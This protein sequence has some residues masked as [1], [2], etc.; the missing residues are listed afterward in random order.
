MVAAALLAV[1][2]AA[3]GILG[4]AATVSKVRRDWREGSRLKYERNNTVRLPICSDE[5]ISR[6]S[7]WPGFNWVIL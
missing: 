5:V 3:T 4:G 6:P 2:G 1:G 7:L